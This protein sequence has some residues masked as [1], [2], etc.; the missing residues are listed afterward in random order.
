[1]RSSAGGSWWFARRTMTLR[2]RH[3]P[4]RWP[5]LCFWLALFAVAVTVLV[6]EPFFGD[7]SRRAP[8]SC[9]RAPRPLAP[10]AD[11]EVLV[12]SRDPA[13][14]GVSALGF[15][16]DD[17]LLVAPPTPEKVVPAEGRRVAVAESRGPAGVLEKRGFGDQVSLH[18]RPAETR[19]PECLSQRYNA[20]LPTATVVVCFHD[21]A[22]STL[23]RTVHSVLDTAP[24][25]HLRELLLVDDCSKHEHLKTPL[26]EYVSRLQ[27]VRLLRSGRRL[28]VVGCRMLGAARAL[29][30]VLIFLDSHCECQQGWLEPLLERI[31]GDRW[32]GCTV[33]LSPHPTRMCLTID[34]TR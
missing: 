7:L 6:T 31:A 2:C 12:D 29:G 3:A 1:M 4:H 32:G 14:G 26:S 20:S 27:V 8:V 17:Q 19:H 25:Q 13:A 30:N 24:P 23:L 33:P 16:Q 22:W 5:L 28:G 10:R 15:L 34:I 18:P 21:E 11:L 9:H